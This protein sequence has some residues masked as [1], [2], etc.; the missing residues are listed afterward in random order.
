MGQMTQPTL[1]R[2]EEGENKK[3]RNG[4]TVH[5]FNIIPYSGRSSTFFQLLWLSQN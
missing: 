4:E 1:G 2:K 3:E 5:Q